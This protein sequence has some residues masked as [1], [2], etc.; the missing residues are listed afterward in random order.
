[1]PA[2]ASATG[3]EGSKVRI[4]PYIHV[5]SAAFAVL[6]VSDCC[7]STTNELS[8]RIVGTYVAEDRNS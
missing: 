1:M 4:F 3:V 6:A 5:V 8:V 2:A 7:C